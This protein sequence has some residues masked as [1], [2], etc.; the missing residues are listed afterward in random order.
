MKVLKNMLK[1]QLS[2]NVKARVLNNS[3][4]N[5]Y[6]PTEGKKVRAQVEQYIYLQSKKINPNPDEEIP[7]NKIATT[8]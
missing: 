4:S 6:V 8:S 2:D 5:E 3:L 1:I 7:P